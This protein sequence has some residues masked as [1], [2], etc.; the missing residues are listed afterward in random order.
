MR[1]IWV[2]KKGLFVGTAA[3]GLLSIGGVSAQAALVEFV[4]WAAVPASATVPE[5][6]YDTTLGLQAG[7]GA[8]GNGDGNLPVANQTPGGLQVDTVVN[9]PIPFSFP[10]SLF[11]GG[12]GYYDVTLSFTGL[13]PIGPAS[14]QLVGPFTEDSQLLGPG[15]FTLTST[16]PA[17][18]VVLL[19]GTIQGATVV[20]GIAGGNAAASF[21][22]DGVSYIGG[23]IAA[24]LPANAVLS[25][26]DMSISMTAVE[27]PLGINPN[28]L[29]LASFTADATGIFDVN[30]VPEPTTIS[31]LALGTAA[32]GFRRRRKA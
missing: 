9:A 12:T 18:S 21:N 11:T 19:T 1:N 30:V 17:G 32:L 6:N 26:N 13:T 25:G 29:Q 27:P 24:A 22:A 23:V 7:P 5:I 3:L 8:I 20:T 15:T 4:N 31:L 14:Q 16:A 10:D 2:A 28:T